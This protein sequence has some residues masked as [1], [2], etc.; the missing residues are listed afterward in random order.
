MIEEGDTR[1]AIGEIEKVLEQAP[2]NISAISW[3]AFAYLDSGNLTRL[4]TL[5]EERQSLFAKNYLWRQ[6]WALLLAVEG[7]REQAIQ[8]MD[9]ETLKFA[10]AAFPSTI[11]VAEFYAVLGDTDRAIEWLERTVRN[12]DERTTWFRNSP[13]L[14]TIRHDAR[15]RR[16]IDSIESRRDKPAK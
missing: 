8:A 9:D 5:L 15:F 4:R 2:N 3:L 12:G 16:I 11:G 1:G 10:A 6:L 13:R 14:A 7:R